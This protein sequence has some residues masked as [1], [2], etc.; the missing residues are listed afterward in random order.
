MTVGAKFFVPIEVAGPTGATAATRFAGGTASGSPASGSFLKGDF[1]ITQDGHVFICTTAGSPGTWADVG[2]GGG[3]FSNPMTT[4]GDIIIENAT[5]APARLALGAAGTLLGQAS[6]LPAWVVPPGYEYDYVEITSAVTV[7]STTQA[8][9][10]TVITGNAVTYDGSTRVKIE[11]FFPYATIIA[12]QSFRLVLWDGS[13]E[14]G[15]MA[16]LV[17]STGNSQFTFSAQRFL[18]PS[19]AAHT[20]SIRAYSS[21][22]TTSA[23]GAGA[24]TSGNFMP[25]FLRITKA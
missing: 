4:A 20:Y 17:G 11:A 24:G 12:G 21:G 22:G 23:C 2:G 7:V 15:A 19:A 9:P 5:P 18:T 16:S 6:S 3:G 14:V 13:S 1:V 10:T 25:A 8:T